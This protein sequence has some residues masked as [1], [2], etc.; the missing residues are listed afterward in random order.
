MK[1]SLISGTFVIARKQWSMMGWPATS[2]SGCASQLYGGLDS[3]RFGGGT[4]GTSRESGRKRVPLDG[5]PT[6]GLSAMIVL[7]EG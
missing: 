7:R 5:P 4:L 6:C 3:E 2:K 1:T